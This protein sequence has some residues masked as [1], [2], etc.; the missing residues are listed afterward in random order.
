MPFQ[1]DAIVI[2]DNKATAQIY[3]GN[4]GN[5]SL[6][7]ETK[8]AGEDTT[9][10]A[11][12]NSTALPSKYCRN[13]KC[14]A[15]GGIAGKLADT[16]IQYLPESKSTPKR[17]LFLTTAE[18][19]VNNADFITRKNSNNNWSTLLSSSTAPQTCTNNLAGPSSVSAPLRSNA[20][21]SGG[22]GGCYVINTD[23]AGEYYVA[24]FLCQSSDKCFEQPNYYIKPDGT[25]STSVSDISI[26]FGKK[27]QSAEQ[28]NS[29][30][31]A[32]GAIRIS[33]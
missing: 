22:E 10:A 21:V 5:S 12:S 17:W 2:D 14:T 25:I 31:G 6:A 9:F 23:K 19:I 29:G 18:S 16:K 4:G 8:R 28:P 24:L 26:T 13:K 33:W 30:N 3:L 32:G 1:N 11:K 7:D 20:A 15:T 27:D